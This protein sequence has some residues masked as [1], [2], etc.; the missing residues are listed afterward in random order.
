MTGRDKRCRQKRRLLCYTAIAWRALVYGLYL[1]GFV[2]SSQ[3]K[4]Y[5]IAL[6]EGIGY[7]H[8]GYTS[9]RC[10]GEH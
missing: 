5:C 7:T 3:S 10:V 6:P 1:A 2:L 8:E 4:R 9:N